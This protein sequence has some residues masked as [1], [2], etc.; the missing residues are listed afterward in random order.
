MGIKSG[1]IER[2]YCFHWWEDFLEYKP[3]AH[4]IAYTL[5]AFESN[6]IVFVFK[7]THRQ[8]FVS[9]KSYDQS[10]P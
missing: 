4:P 2:N 8:K 10:C 3:L 1:D 5:L 9:A 6:A 7:K